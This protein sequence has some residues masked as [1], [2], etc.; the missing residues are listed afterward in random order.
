MRTTFHLK[1]LAVAIATLSVASV[2]NAA[3]LDRSGQDVTAF[4]Q[5]GT[6]AEAVYTYIDADVSGYD[7]SN[8]NP[9]Q[10]DYERGDKTGDIAESYDFFR[11][12]VKTD[13][14]DTFS[15][16]VLYDEPFGAAAEYTQSNFVASNN[17]QASGGEL[18]GDGV[19]PQTAGAIALAEASTA[20]ENTNVEVRSQSLT[21]ILGMKFGANKNFQIYGGPVA[22]RIQSET[23]LRGLAYGPASGYT[24]NSNP[25]MD[26]GYIAGIAYSKPE[27]ALKAALTYRSE[28]DHDIGISENY[29]I[30]GILAQGAALQQG[31]TPAQAAAIGAAAANRNSNYE[32]TTPKSVNFDFQTGIN[33]TTL[34]TAK[35]RWVPWSDF[36]ITPPLYNDVSKRNYGPDGLDLVEY[37][38]DQWQVELGLAKRV[39]PALAIS[40][41]VGWDSGAGDPTTSLGPVDGYYSVGLGAKYNVTENW[42]VSAGGKYL[43]F[44]DAKGRL[45]SGKIVGDFQDNDGYIAGLKLSYQGE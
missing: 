43:W 10:N 20:G 27:I 35:V 28:I 13:I 32:I 33:P 23:K 8:V 11:Y 29:P 42:A 7:S 26:Y 19:D 5:D 22:Q 24:S 36:A 6:Y 17:P 3:G 44:G 4:F 16:G 14:N 15:V 38:D 2:T 21:G 34:A 37:E 41:T 39:A 45:P 1:T 12:G 25:D 31:A 40:G 18:V 9:G 30:A